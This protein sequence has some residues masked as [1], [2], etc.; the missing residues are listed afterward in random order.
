MLR[1]TVAFAVL[2]VGASHAKTKKK[3]DVEDGLPT[4]EEV[5]VQVR[6]VYDELATNSNPLVRR[7]VFEG[8]LAL[9]DAGRLKAVGEGMKESDW[10]IRGEALALAFGPAPKQVRRDWKALRKAAEAQ[11]TKLLESGEADDRAHGLAL[12][13]AHFKPKAQ[14]KWLEKA[15]RLGTPDARHAAREALLARGGKVAWKVIQ[16]GLVEAED[17]R[18]YKQALEALKGFTDP[19]VLK[20]ALGKLHEDTPM[21]DIGRDLLVAIDDKRAVK[22]MLKQLKREYEKS[23]EFER[24][25]RIASVLARRGD[26]TVTRTLLAG[27]RYQKKAF[28]IY[29]W[30]GLLGVRDVATLGKL[31]AYVLSNDKEAEADAAFAWLQAWAAARAEPK[32]FEVLQEAAR[33]DRRPLRLRGMNVLAALKHTPSIALFEAAMSE[34]Q[35]EVRLAGARGIASVARPGHEK[36]L[37]TFL[38]KEPDPDV[39]IELVTG[40]ANIGTPEIIGPLQYVIAAPQREL[41]LAAVKAIAA[42]GSPDAALPLSLLKR[43]ADVN[44]RFVV[45]HN[46]LRLQPRKTVAELKSQLSWLTVEH[47]DTLGEDV[48]VPLETLELLAAQGSDDQRTFA[49]SAMNARGGAAATRLLGLVESQHEDTAAAAMAAL[50]KL[51]GD[52]SVA[53]YRKALK[54]KHGAVRAAGYAA[55]GQFGPRALLETV[56]GGMADREPLARA[57]AAAASVL[58]AARPA[59]EPT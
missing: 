44:I 40:L 6:A 16:A 36:S 14:L 52:K 13:K 19:L 34:G 55:I 35:K 28:R 23:A 56:L 43:D 38:R 27:L 59:A 32:V 57:R 48:K 22:K 8:R 10:V 50:T 45:W 53:T 33:S 25:L 11:L 5:S 42:T 20:W 1:L 3:A 29:T 58:L 2:A 46:L 39:K 51:R 21:G 54:S 37:H 49:I 30:Q 31:R 4:V 7:A 26:Q 17:S 41:K 12:L 9:D 24:R 15:A 47:I 18:E